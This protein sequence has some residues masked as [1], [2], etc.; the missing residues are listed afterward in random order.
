MAMANI[1]AAILRVSIVISLAFFL[2]TGCGAIFTN[3]DQGYNSLSCAVLGYL[4][5]SF[6]SPDAML[7]TVK[8]ERVDNNCYPVKTYVEHNALIMET[9]NAVVMAIV[10]SRLKPGKHTFIYLW[11]SN[12]AVIDSVIIPVALLP[13]QKA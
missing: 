8:F 6:E 5:T 2:L 1:K 7:P 13:K 12:T 4:H 3:D 10:P 11:H 9:K